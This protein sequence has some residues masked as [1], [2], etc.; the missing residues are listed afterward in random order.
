MCYAT[1]DN[2][3]ATINLLNKDADIAIVVGGYNSS[4][5]SHIVDLCS[6]KLPTYFI[7]HSTEIVDKNNINHFLYNEKKL[8][9]TNGYLPVK[10][11]LR[12][13][14]TSGAS[15]P[16]NIVD[17]VLERILSFYPDSKSKETVLSEII[18]N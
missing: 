8:V 5:T 18:R 17:S 14:L 13:I 9:K 4:N 15:C 7:N 1:N 2:Q 16:D 12:I 6:E 10:N 3:Q 11:P